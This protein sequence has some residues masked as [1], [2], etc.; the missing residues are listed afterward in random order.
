[1]TTKPVIHN[2]VPPEGVCPDHGE[3]ASEASWLRR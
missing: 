1:M 2:S 3:I